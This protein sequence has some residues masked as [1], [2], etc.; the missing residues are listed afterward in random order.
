MDFLKIVLIAAVVLLVLLVGAM[1]FFFRFAHLRKD[2]VLENMA[3]DGPVWRAYKKNIEDGTHWLENQ[4]KEEVWTTSFDGLKLRG[5]Y[6]PVEDPKACV[7]LFHGYRSSGIQDFG[8]LL[9]FYAE[10]GFSVLMVTQRACGESEGKYITFGIKERKDALR[11]A[12]YM[13]E[14]LQGNLPILLHG[15]SMGA[16]AVMMAAN[17]PLPKRV[18]GLVADCGF[19]APYDIIAHCGKQWFKLPAFPLVNMLSGVSKM[20]TGCGYRD[21]STLDTLAESVLPVLLIHGGKDTFVPTYMTELNFKAAKN[22]VGKL[23]VPDASHALSYLM[24]PE[25]YQRELMEFAGKTVCA[26]D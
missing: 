10:K 11:W 5:T 12:E 18:V 3:Q 16:S 7:I 26:A 21:C 4:N 14:R 20:I 19:T 9:P 23:I 22:C 15:L 1:F 6:I 13:D 25:G 17:L 2:Y 8:G 24:D